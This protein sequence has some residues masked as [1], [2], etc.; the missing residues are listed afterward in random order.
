[1]KEAH[2]W[3]QLL[4]LSLT[5]IVI[6]YKKG[7][8]AAL[9]DKHLGEAVKRAL[10]DLKVGETKVTYGYEDVKKPEFLD[11]GF[12]VPTVDEVMRDETKRKKFARALSRELRRIGMNV[13][14]GEV[15][16]VLLQVFPI[17]KDLSKRLEQEWDPSLRNKGSHIDEKFLLGLPEFQKYLKYLE[18]YAG[19]KRKETELKK[20]LSSSSQRGSGSIEEV[21]LEVLS[22]LQAL[23][24]LDYSEEAMNKT[25]KELEGRIR[26]IEGLDAPWLE[27]VCRLGI[28]HLALVYIKKKE[29]KKAEEVFKRL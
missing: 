16:K 5:P 25:V 11:D 12:Y 23:K 19:L 9:F 24:M 2:L 20:T 14:S 1:M 13:D 17:A 27:D 18:A 10:L 4:H 22:M 28:Y 7:R 29:F 3:R 15:E 8:P 21:K 6:K 26:E